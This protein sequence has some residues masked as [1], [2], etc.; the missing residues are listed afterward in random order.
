[1]SLGH[2]NHPL[3]RASLYSPCLSPVAET[4]GAGEGSSCTNG[5]RDSRQFLSSL[6][7]PQSLSLSHCQMLL[8]QLPL[9]HLY[10]LE[11]QV[12]SGAH[13]QRRGR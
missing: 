10:W 12:F 7:S 8:M 9:E 13:P 2:S 3:T 11:R 5:P 6:M 4:A 1:M